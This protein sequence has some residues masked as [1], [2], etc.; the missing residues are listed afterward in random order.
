MDSDEGFIV[1]VN[2]ILSTFSGRC[3]RNE[4]RRFVAWGLGRPQSPCAASQYKMYEN[5]KKFAILVAAFC[6]MW[7]VARVRGHAVALYSYHSETS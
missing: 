7:P 3:T 4:Q 1:C 6:G 2:G 5:Y